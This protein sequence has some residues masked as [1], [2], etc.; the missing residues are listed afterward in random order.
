MKNNTFSTIGILG[1][2]L[3]FSGTV[4]AQGMMSLPNSLPDNAAIQSQQ[5]EEQEGKKFLDDLNSK[6]VACSN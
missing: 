1:I 3:L 5:R 2:F 4:F 6:A